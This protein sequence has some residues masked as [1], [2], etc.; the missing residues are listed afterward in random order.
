MNGYARNYPTQLWTDKRFEKAAIG[1]HYGGGY[2]TSRRPCPVC[3][4]KGVRFWMETN[5]V[6]FF[7]CSR[8]TY[9]DTRDVE[10]FADLRYSGGHHKMFNFGG[11][12]KK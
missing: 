10:K 8:C 6:G 2:T 9:T 3:M 12:V 7:R 1:S 5:R 4:E 11:Q